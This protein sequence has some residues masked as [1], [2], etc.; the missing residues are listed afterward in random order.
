M[1]PTNFGSP[2]IY[3]IVVRGRLERRAG[4][5]LAGMQVALMSG[6]GDGCVTMLTGFLRDQAALNGILNT[7]YELHLTVLEVEKLK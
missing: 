2:G 1:T 3:R 4:E 7:L 6:G 5:T